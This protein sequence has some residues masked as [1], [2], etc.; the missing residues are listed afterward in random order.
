MMVLSFFVSMVATNGEFLFEY[1]ESQ[2]SISFGKSCSSLDVYLLQL[3]GVMFKFVSKMEF[4]LNLEGGC[5]F[6]FVLLVCII[7][8]S[9]VEPYSK[10]T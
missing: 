4:I 9:K 7:G 1:V 3:S 5:I 8:M 6:Y 10:R 2:E